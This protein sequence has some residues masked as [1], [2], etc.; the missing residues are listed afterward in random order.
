MRTAELR[1]WRTWTYRG[2][3]VAVLG[4]LGVL[5]MSWLIGSAVHA[6]ANAAVAEYGGDRVNALIA[7]ADSPSHSLRDRN[8]AVWALG[9]IGDR[10]AL[11]FLEK[12]HTGKLCDHDRMLCQHELA[13]SIRLCRGGVNLP[14]VVWRPGR[15]SGAD[16]TP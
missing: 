5:T 6:V 8:R 7:Y 14:A 16:S 11:P 4:T 9:Q 13:K 3:L 12:Q 10:R 15:M 1:R 2:L